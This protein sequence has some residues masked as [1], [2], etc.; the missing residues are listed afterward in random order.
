MPI[1]PDRQYLTALSAAKNTLVS[2]VISAIRRPLTMP[3]STGSAARGPP[4]KHVCTNMKLLLDVSAVQRVRGCARPTYVSHHVCKRLSCN[5]TVGVRRLLNA[6]CTGRQ[7]CSIV[8]SWSSPGVCVCVCVRE[9]SCTVTGHSVC[10]FVY[11]SL[12]H[13]IAA[14][15]CWSHGGQCVREHGQLHTYLQTC[16]ASMR[17]EGREVSGP[18]ILVTKRERGRLHTIHCCT[19]H[20]LALLTLCPFHDQTCLLYASPSDQ[21]AS[22]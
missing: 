6:F 16:C 14:H 13:P 7:E 17:R 20:L 10:A 15:A 9:R 2:L 18:G 1:N 5:E 3:S 4:C 11:H 8:D 12:A 22:W 21:T 19:R